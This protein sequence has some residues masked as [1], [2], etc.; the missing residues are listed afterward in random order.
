M[1]TRKHGAR[2]RQTTLERLHTMLVERQRRLLEGEDAQA[3]G[4][5]EQPQYISADELEMAA[6]LSDREILYWISQQHSEELSGIGEAFKKMQEGSY[7][8]CEE[9]D[10]PIRAARLRALP[11]ARLC[12]R[13]QRE[14]ERCA[15]LEDDSECWGTIGGSC[16]ADSSSD[17]RC[18]RTTSR[19]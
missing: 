11:H 10:S 4:R 18:I 7:G 8:I 6:D 17:S 5:S 19:R 12:V 16:G 15:E 9:C 14:R 13:C 2:L 1:G 3:A